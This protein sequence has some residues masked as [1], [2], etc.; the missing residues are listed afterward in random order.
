MALKIRL[1]RGGATH[2]AHYK[3]VVVESTKQRDGQAVDVIGHYH[4]N[5]HNEQRF[6]IN[7]EKLNK[8]TSFGAKPT[9][10]IVRLGLKNGISSLEKFAVKHTHGKTY[11][12]TRK[13]L[14][15][16]VKA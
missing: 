13:E 6:I 5:Y 3:I 2:D 15:N 12:K 1:A 8:W 11:G 16:A 10:V 14:K 4:P 7:A 9:Q